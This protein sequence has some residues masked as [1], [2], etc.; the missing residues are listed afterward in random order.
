MMN[1][2]AYIFVKNENFLAGKEGFVIC[3][4][5]FR[6]RRSFI[7]AVPVFME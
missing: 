4:T 6:T 2:L 7:N 5:V 3:I 1:Y